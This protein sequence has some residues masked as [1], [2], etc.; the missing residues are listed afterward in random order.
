MK[1]L[2]SSIKSH[3]S[4]RGNLGEAD[5]GGAELTTFGIGWRI[6]NTFVGG[7]FFASVSDESGHEANKGDDLSKTVSWRQVSSGC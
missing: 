7:E 6:D 5:E 3:S 1:N 2:L 4:G